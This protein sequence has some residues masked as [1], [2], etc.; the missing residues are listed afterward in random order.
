M[1]ERQVRVTA[2]A[3]RTY[4]GGLT[5]PER[6]A[7]W[8]PRAGD[9]LVCTPPKSGTTWTQTMLAMLLHGGPDLPDKV[10]ALSPWVDSALGEAAEVTRRL[11]AQT[12]RRV[13]KTHTPADGFPVWEGVTVVAIYRHPL[14]VF[15]S[16]R[17][18]AV[19]MKQP[20]DH[21]MRL[22]VAASL[23][24]FLT[25][26]AEPDNF[27]RDTLATVVCHYAQ[28]ALSGR[29]PGLVKL[30]YA[31][32]V[33]DHHAALRNLAAGVGLQVSE[34]VIDRI[35]AATDIAAMRAKATEFAP[36]GGTG[37]WASDAA[38]FDSGGAG[39]WRGQVTDEALARYR[40]RFA[41][42]LPDPAARA[43]LEW[44]EG[45]LGKDA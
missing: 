35:A 1:T 5:T 3:M 29:V 38:F 31:D 2:P 41:V 19:N 36:E 21:P 45:A 24:A 34:A 7:T 6:W 22:P 30:H 8:T 26:P 17:K 13:V 33:A 18:H 16:L 10:G 12:G 43:W 9:I 39:K 11:A 25:G 40:E 27:D 23:D 42:L 20:E 15:F 37:L 32:M 4:R 28:T 14:D 44:G